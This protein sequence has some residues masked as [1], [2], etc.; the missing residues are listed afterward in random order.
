MQEQRQ[1]WLMRQYIDHVLEQPL[2]LERKLS[3]LR[4]RGV[5][6]PVQ[7]RVLKLTE[8]DPDP[9]AVIAHAH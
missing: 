1:D 6:W 8:R 4:E 7:L 2:P 5:P 9:E 3:H